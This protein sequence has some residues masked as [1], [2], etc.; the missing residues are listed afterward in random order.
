MPNAKELIERAGIFEE[1]AF[2]MEHLTC[3][4]NAASKV[5]HNLA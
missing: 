2:A 5:Q 1:R 4:R 3:S